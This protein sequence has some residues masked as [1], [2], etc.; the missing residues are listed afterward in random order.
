MFG[1]KIHCHL[2]ENYSLSLYLYIIFSQNLCMQWEMGQQIIY[3]FVL[4][5]VFQIHLL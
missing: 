1:R 4:N 3:I 5:F 2:E